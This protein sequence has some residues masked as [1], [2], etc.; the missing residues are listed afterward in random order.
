MH[1]GGYKGEDTQS[2]QHEGDSAST[3]HTY[4]GIALQYHRQFPTSMEV[5]D[6]RWKCEHSAIPDFQW[7]LG[8][9]ELAFNT[10]RASTGCSLESLVST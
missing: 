3:I 8:I 4:D 1:E 9:A 5:G 6:S 7:K 10:T 2:R